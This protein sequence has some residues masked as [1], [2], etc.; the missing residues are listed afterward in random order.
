MLAIVIN[1]GHNTNFQTVVSLVARA[2][3]EERS[4]F[5]KMV[6]QIGNFLILL[7]IALVMLIVVVALFRHESL[8]EIARFAMVLTVAA[9][10]VALPAVMSVTMA[11]GAVN[12]ARHKAIVSRLTA[13]EEMAGVDILCADKTGTLTKNE[14]SVAEP[15]VLGGFNRR[16]LFLVAA[17][18][19]K[20]ENRDPI[21]IP[22]F[23][24]IDD[25]YPDLDLNIYRQIQF[26]PFDPIRKR[27]EA[28]IERGNDHFV[29][30]KG[31]AQVLLERA[32]LAEKDEQLIRDEVDRLASRGYRTLAVGRKRGDEPVELLGLIPFHDPLREDSQTVIDEMRDYGVKVKM[33]TGDNVAIAREIGSLLGLEPR[34][35]RA[36]QLFGEAGNELLSLIE[37][38][39]IATYQRLKPEMSH[40]A[41]QA[42]AE[43]VMASVEQMYDTRLLEREFVHTRQAAIVDLIESVEIFAEVVPEDK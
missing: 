22:I 32:E 15:V 9:I 17:L 33:V 38:V 16:E 19:S 13:I 2:Q 23:D 6:I 37:V 14:M 28:A 40:H 34:A 4:H 5:Q 35:M 42:F 27:T 36:R 41:A 18:A 21:E 31:A 20:Q 25:H 43:G 7:T 10:P 39:T 12:L 24:Y 1:T 11:V 26:T 30:M 3:L 8:M 29:A